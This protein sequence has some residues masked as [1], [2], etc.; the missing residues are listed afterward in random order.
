MGILKQSQRLVICLEKPGC[1]EYTVR[2]KTESQK[3]DYSYSCKR[4]VR[5]KD[6]QSRNRQEEK[7]QDKMVKEPF[8]GKVGL[9][10]KSHKGATEQPV[11]DEIC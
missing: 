2:N 9:V 11:T 4:T 6:E 3:N 1:K 7:P 5:Y 8:P 10:Q